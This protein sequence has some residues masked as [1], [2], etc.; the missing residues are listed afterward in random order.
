MYDVVD[1]DA[2][3]NTV[4]YPAGNKVTTSEPYL[5]AYNYFSRCCEHAKIVLAVGYSFRDY[6]ALTSL[7]KARQVNDNLTLLLLSPEAYSVLKA[8]PDDDTLG[9]TRPIFGRFGDHASE[10]KYLSEI[11]G[12][13]VHSF[14][15]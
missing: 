6:D 2:Y 4:I 13:I 8:I 11:E 14:K 12:W 7:L 10:S 15:K 1:S 5:T 3:Q 9:W